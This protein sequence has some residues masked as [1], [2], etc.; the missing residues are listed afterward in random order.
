MPDET[1]VKP[2]RPG[3]AR[4]APACLVFVEGD[5]SWLGRTVPLEGEITLGRDA[6]CAV[7]L[8]G[9][10]VSRRH[11][12]VAPEGDG[13]AVVDLGSTNG[14]LVNGEAVASVRR[15]SP[16]DRIAIGPYVAKYLGPNDPEATLHA[17]LHRRATAD[18]LTGLP[19]RRAF[20]EA[21]AREVARARRAGTPL[22][23]LLVDV[24][25]FKRVNDE[26]GHPA[27]DEVLRAVAGRIASAARAGD[28]V[29]RVGGEEFALALPGAGAADAREAGERVRARV[30]DGPVALEGGDLAVTVS[31]GVASLGEPPEEGPD[32]VARADEALYRAKR[33]GRNRVEG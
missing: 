21:L 9:E 12:R 20:E 32:L 29:G 18:A 2:P 22:G 28:L 16:G 14:T 24:D 13:H 17:E 11:A 5:P 19:N 1:R 7:R 10:D 33:A 31:V 27:G 4:P 6:A 3:D 25:H 15:L 30:A 23:L 8:D 26:R